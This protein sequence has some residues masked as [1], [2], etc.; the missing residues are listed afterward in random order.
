MAPRWDG[1]LPCAGTRVQQLQTPA[2][3]VGIGQPKGTKTGDKVIDWVLTDFGHS[4]W[5]EMEAALQEGIDTVR[6]VLTL[7][8]YK[9]VSGA[10]A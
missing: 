3:P 6:A 10:R 9:A 8:M 2:W 7:G 4:E 5:Q 1:P